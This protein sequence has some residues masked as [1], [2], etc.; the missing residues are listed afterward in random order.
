MS[1][2]IGANI[3]TEQPLSRS[4]RRGIGWVTI[5]K[6]AGPND[7]T[8]IGAKEDDILLTAPE[9]IRTQKG[10]V[11][12]I[13]AEYPNVSGG[14]AFEEDTENEQNAIWELI[15]QEI[16]KPLATHPVFQ[17][18]GLSVEFIEKIEKAI[19]EGVAT[20][21]DWN[22]ES[23][24]IQCNNYRNLRVRGVESYRIWSHIIR[25]SFSSSRESLLKA[26]EA[27]TQKVV[28][29]DQI[30]LPTTVKWSQPGIRVW[31]GAAVVEPV[32]HLLNEWLVGPPTIR[33]EGKKFTISKEWVG[34]EKWYAILYEGGTALT[35]SNGWAKW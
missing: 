7:E 27:N 26:A 16:D 1:T 9:S 31:D 13:E 22:T 35:T 23:G 2:V 4:Y 20:E 19:K 24:L 25:K 28:T 21:T 6:W 32:P 15:P 8:L 33:Y 34:A 18:S 5:R 10:V 29:Y 3:F 12:F 17:E 14:Q 11:T 30:G